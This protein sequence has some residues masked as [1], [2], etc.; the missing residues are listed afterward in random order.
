MRRP[1]RTCSPECT[2]TLPRK[3]GVALRA[4]AEVCAHALQRLARDGVAPQGLGCICLLYTS[5]SPRD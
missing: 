3:A 1:L 2:P 4:R 5:P